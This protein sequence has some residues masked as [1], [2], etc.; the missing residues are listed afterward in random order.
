MRAAICEEALYYYFSNP[1]SITRVKWS[2]RR[3]DQI[4]AHAQRYAFLQDAGYSQA[5]KRELEAYTTAMF[6]QAQDLRLLSKEDRSYREQQKQMHRQMMPVFRMARK[7]GLFPFAPDNVWMYE[8]AYPV[9]PVWIARN[10]LEKL[11]KR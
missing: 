6:A 1:N 2:P 4:E 3:L 10:L 11:L 8:L 5:A 9:K 7:Q